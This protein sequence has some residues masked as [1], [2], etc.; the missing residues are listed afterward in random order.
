MTSFP[1]VAP[2]PALVDLLEVVIHGDE[3]EPLARCGSLIRRA[4]SLG[5]VRDADATHGRS[6]VETPEGLAVYKRW[7]R[8]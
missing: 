2:D 3:H 8:A 4:K 7:R 1:E 6:L 5:W